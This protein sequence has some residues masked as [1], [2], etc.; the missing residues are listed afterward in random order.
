MPTRHQTEANEEQLALV[1]SR[2]TVR[3]AGILG[4]SNA[5]LSRVLGLSESQVSRIS[6]DQ[7][8]LEGKAQEL[9][10]LFVR[11]FRGLEGILGNDDVAARAWLTTPNTALRAKPLDMIQTVQGL[12]EAVLYVDSRRAEI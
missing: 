8:T 6:R 7:A 3:S 9:G 1:I 10:L 5:I 11:L 12:M 4:L 2:A